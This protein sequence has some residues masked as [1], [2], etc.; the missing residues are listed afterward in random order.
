MHA[1]K[2]QEYEKKLHENLLF[3]VANSNNQT[4]TTEA[5]PKSAIPIPTTNS[6]STFKSSSKENVSAPLSSSVSSSSSTTSNSS[7]TNKENWPHLNNG[8]KEKKEKEK[9]KKTKGKG[10][11][12][13][14]GS[15]KPDRKEAYSG[16]NDV[17]MKLEKG[18]GLGGKFNL[19]GFLS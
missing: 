10:S 16:R 6:S 15:R 7:G 2:H 3:R 18:F 8:D 9:G 11:G 14:G 13:D 17:G 4:N 5:N 19:C 12:G 1:G